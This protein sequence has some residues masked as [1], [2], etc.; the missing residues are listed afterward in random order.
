MPRVKRGV[1]ALK[2]RKNTLAQAKGYRHGRSS[3][4]RQAKD[5]LY[6]AG[7]R[8]FGDRR[9]KK[10]DFRKLW[11]I[12]INAATRTHGLSY[13][14]FIHALKEKGIGLNR[15]M[16]AELAEYTPE[17]FGKIVDEAKK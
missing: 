10:G 8:A 14:T 17:M 3:K 5:A 7:V 1:T 9:G 6:H 4:E 16:L 15:K 12:Q 11:Q 2:R 13:S